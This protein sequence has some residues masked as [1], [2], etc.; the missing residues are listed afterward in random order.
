[1]EQYLTHTDY[2][3]WEVIING[4]SPVPEPP[5]VGTVVPSKSEAQKFIKKNKLKA[6]STLL[7]AISNEHLLKFHSIKDAK[8]LREAIKIRSQLVLIRQKLNVTITTKEV[9]L[10]ENV[11]HQ[12]IKSYQ[13]EE[14]PTDFALMSYS[15]DLENS[16]NF[17]LEETMKEKADLKEKLTKFEESS[18]NLTKLINSQ[19]SANDKTGLG[20]DS[21]LSENEMPK[22]EIF[23]TA[24][25]S[26]VRR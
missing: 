18:K 1:M 23:E 13:A 2:A 26:S 14:G 16:S 25:D 5:A 3:I 21:Q 7:L 19:I 6:K 10:L 24:S 15:L 8:Y 17:E 9:I 20:Y 4:D 12:G 22:C 11:V